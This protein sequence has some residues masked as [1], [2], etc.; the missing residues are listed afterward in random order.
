MKQS[1]LSYND[2][3]SPEYFLIASQL[4]QIAEDLK[5][6]ETD[7]S[8]AYTDD[9]LNETIDSLMPE[10]FDFDKNNEL[11][12]NK[13][14]LLYETFGDEEFVKKFTNGK[15]GD[16]AVEDIL[17]RSILTSTEKMKKIVKEGAD[18]ILNSGDPFIE[19][20][21]Y[22]DQKSELISVRY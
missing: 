21:Q 4:I 9:E 20:I 17:S 10:D 14:D 11:L 5:L 19:F 18:A 8:Y 6:S 16:E 3:D 13:I 7:S 12:K 2:F 1:A 15:R 22:S